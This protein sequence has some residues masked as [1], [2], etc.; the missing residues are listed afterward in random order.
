[1]ATWP[2]ELPN[3]PLVEGFEDFPRDSVVRTQ[4][5][6]FTKYRNRFTAV[7][8]DVSENYLL[9]PSQFTILRNFYEFTLKNGSLIFIKN[10]P[11]EQQNREYRFLEP[12]Q[13]E[14]DGVFYKL[15]LQLEK[16]P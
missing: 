10:D 11:V 2:T 9:T 3:T 8:H 7:I 12:Y 14:F 13:F 15:T 1:M 16:L 6:G 4:M 5:A